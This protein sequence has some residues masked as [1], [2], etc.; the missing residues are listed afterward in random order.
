MGKALESGQNPNY[1]ANTSIYPDFLPQ[2]VG[3]TIEALAPEK[4]THD[5]DAIGS[6]IVFLRQERATKRRSDSECSKKV[7]RSAEHLGGSGLTVN[8]HIARFLFY[9]G[10]L[11]E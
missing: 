10:K 5:N 9:C 6:G 3:P 1:C 2:D 7:Y 4:I 8:N 11:R